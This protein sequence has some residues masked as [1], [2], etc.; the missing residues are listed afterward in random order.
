M[1]NTLETSIYTFGGLI[2]FSAT[3]SWSP[4]VPRQSLSIDF[5]LLRLLW[6]APPP[7][8]LGDP[9][10]RANGGLVHEISKALLAF[11]DA[12]VDSLCACVD[13]QCACVESQCA[14]VDS[15]CACANSPIR[16]LNSSIA[17]TNRSNEIR[18]GPT[19]HPSPQTISTSSSFCTWALRPPKSISGHSHFLPHPCALFAC[20]SPLVSVVDELARYAR[21]GTTN[22]PIETASPLSLC[23][24]LLAS[25]AFLCASSRFFLLLLA[26][27]NSALP[28]LVKPLHL[29]PVTLL[30][31][32]PAS[33]LFLLPGSHLLVFSVFLF[34]LTPATLFGLGRH[35]I[36]VI[37]RYP[38]QARGS[39]DEPSRYWAWRGQEW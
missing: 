37:T 10:A 20:R 24:F 36:I 8:P 7:T 22:T 35:D 25:V 2:R 29:F 14:C 15:L 1:Y 9:P 21:A 16:P 34:D 19:R 11:L 12:S 31:F 30:L 5:F 32:F 18:L 13:S 33:F 3:S 6:S 26:F 28:L 4:P 23:L 27:P 39:G 38:S 17:T